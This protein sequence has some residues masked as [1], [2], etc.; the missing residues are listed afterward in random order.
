MSREYI[1][2]LKESL[3]KKVKV[4]DEILRIC[5]YQSE[6]LSKEEFDYEAFDAYM[7]DR[8]I[9]LDKLDKLDSGFELVY[10]RVADDLKSNKGEYADLIKDMQSLISEITDKSAAIN[11]ADKRNKQS[12]DN[13]FIRDRRKI[14][15]GRRSVTVAMN[16]YK[17]MTN[18]SASG[19]QF[20]DDKK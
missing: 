16:Y 2:A 9:C 3:E 4:L 1:T 11:A 12:V 19:G 5:Q 15:E 17:N 13:I 6:L 18:M 7:D 10:Q 14:G 20:M 8:D